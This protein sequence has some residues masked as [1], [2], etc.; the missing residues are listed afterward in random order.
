M[1][2]F[3]ALEPLVSNVL[4]VPIDMAWFGEFLVSKPMF[5]FV[6]IWTWKEGGRVPSLLL[7]G[8]CLA[9]AV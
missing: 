2:G 4:T 8:R 3:C 7:I 5:R 1:L 6:K 9:L